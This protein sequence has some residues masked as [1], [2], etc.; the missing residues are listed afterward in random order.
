M[1]LAADRLDDYLK[2]PVRLIEDCL[3]LESGHRYGQVIQP[4]QRQTFRA[5]FARE[6]GGRPKHRL[7]FD[8]R[9][10]GE[11]KTEDTAAAGTTDLLTG[12]PR[13][14]SYVV[15][16]DEDQAALVLDSIRGF[17][18]RSPILAD[19]EIQRNVVRNQATGSELRVM[20]SDDRTA[21]GIRP[22]RVFFDELSLQ[23]DDRLWKAMWSAIG[24]NPASQM[25]AV[26]M[27][28]WDFSSIGWT[29]R[30]LARTTPGYYFATREGSKLAPWLAV[31]DMA[32][33]RKTLH[34][35]DFAR[36]WECRW[37][38]PLG[39]W[40]TREMF[41]ACE[42]GQ[43]SFRGDIANTYAGFVDVGVVHDPTAIA[44]CHRPRGEDLIVLDK[45]ATIQG[46]H[47]HNVDF[48]AIEDMVA[49]LTT[50]FKIRRWVFE[51]P[52]AVASVQRLQRRLPGVSIEVRWP[53][54]DSQGRIFG[55]LYRLFANHQLVIYP[56]ERL[57]KEA[58]SLVTKTS[59]GRLKVVEGSAVHQDHVVA[60]AGA[61]DLLVEQPAMEPARVKRLAE[62]NTELR[63]VGHLDRLSRDWVNNGWTR[64]I[65]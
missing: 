27:A 47:A 13:H 37:T 34:P 29:V 6:K 25:V 59:G 28:G 39:S 46:S 63:H 24:K 65:G 30:E 7:V 50:L 33:Q 20:S 12:P 8:E 1:N 11:S 14:R 31:R 26:S 41:E 10:R 17:K 36:F 64:R 42:T 38:E 55:T 35:A 62:L 22:R 61:C 40:I 23:S 58:L 51:S 60:L 43:E 2:D 57:R 18:S 5:I 21:Y 9:R 52:Q 49:D 53:T 32:E 48:D 54:S 44:V 56:H 45:L 4:W 3:V 16:G 19:V 15:A